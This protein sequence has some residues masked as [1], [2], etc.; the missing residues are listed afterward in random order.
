MK[1]YKIKLE[2]TDNSD[3]IISV[4][5]EDQLAELCLEATGGGWYEWQTMEAMLMSGELRSLGVFRTS[6]GLWVC[7]EI[8]EE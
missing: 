2:P 6:Y 4:L 1:S 7:L 3:F 5:N 8:I